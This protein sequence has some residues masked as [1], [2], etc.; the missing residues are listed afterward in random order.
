MGQSVWK[1]CEGCGRVE[2]GAE[3]LVFGGGV[4]MGVGVKGGDV[5]CGMGVGVT[6]GLVVALSF[7]S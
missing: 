5:V 7:F 4:T 1:W 3:G 2:A 6:V